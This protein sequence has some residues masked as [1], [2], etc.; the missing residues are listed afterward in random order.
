MK[1]VADELFKEFREHSVSEFFRKNAAMLG[2]TGKIRSLTTIV[3]E[4]VTN[5]VTRDTAVIIRVNGATKLARIGELIDGLMEKYREHVQVG[6]VESL[7]TFDEN[8]EVLCFDKMTLKM[9]YKRA[10]SLHRHKLGAGERLFLL[11]TVGGR[12][13]TVTKHHSLFTLSDGKVVPVRVEELRKGDFVIVPR[14]WEMEGWTKKINILEEVLKLPPE[15][16]KDV[17]LY[18]VKKLLYT[19]REL[20]RKIKAP[21]SRH[22]RHYTF[23]SYYMS[24]DRL[25]VNLLRH[26]EAEERKAFGGC[27]ISWRNCRHKLPVVMDVDDDLMVI[28]GLYSAE[29]CIRTNLEQ[30]YLSFGNNERELVE[31]I[32][33]SIERK[34][35]IRP[36]I[37]PAHETAINLVISSK[38]VAF[39]LK[40]VLNA[41]SSAR[42]KKLP[43]IVLNVPSRLREKYLLAYISG[44][45][46]PTALALKL[47]EN[48]GSL[49]DAN[50]KFFACNTIS[51]ELHTGMQY[52][53][54]SLGYSYSSR[55]IKGSE[56]IVKGRRAKFRDSYIIELWG[57]QINSPM[58][59]Y[60]VE[61]GGCRVRDAKICHAI[62]NCDQEAITFH[63]F[64]RL[65][66]DGGITVPDA[67][68]VFRNGDLSALKISEIIEREGAGEYVYDFSVEGDENFVGGFGPICLHNSIDAAEEAGVLPKVNVWIK[69]INEEPEH[70]KVAIEDN[71]SGIPDKY[72]PN[73]FGKML[74]GTKLHRHQ[75][76]RGQQGIGVSGSVM[77]GQIT[78]GKPA[79]VTT[80]TGNGEIVKAGVMIDVDKNEGKIL[81][82]EKLKGNWRG[83]RVEIEA[84]DVSY[85]RSRYGPF[86]YL[87]MTAIANPHVHITFVEP[88]GALTVFENATDEVPERPK[89]MPLHPWGIMS[90]D[91][92][93][94]AKRTKARIVTTFLSTELS[95]VSKRKAEEVCRLAGVPPNRKPLELTWEEAEHIV[96]AFKQVKLLA[97]PTSGLRPIGAADIEKG[98]R[99]ILNP[100]FAYAI[101]RPP[102][103]YRG[104]LPFVVE[105]GIA[106]GGNAGRLA[107]GKGENDEGEGEVGMDLIRFANR[108]PLIF[109]QGGCAI[110]A[111]A[112]NIEWR[113]YGV[114][115]ATAPLTLFVNVSSAYVPYT[116]AGK[117][118]IADEPEILN[119]TRTAIMEAAR[120]LRKFLF[121]K[122]KLK[123]RQERAGVFEEYLPVIARKAASL[124]GLREPDI[125]PLLKKVA[126][127]GDAGES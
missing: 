115:P 31:Y 49:S 14:R 79:T 24:R 38:F 36:S 95:R 96:S 58:N 89:P 19:D 43:E 15:L 70:L 113:R 28:L 3:H 51:R 12:E 37:N 61:S 121:R 13:V 16:T 80:S 74:A 75:Q 69:R 5:S 27:N 124:A 91:L 18:G 125:K 86:N 98:M 21:L 59:L 60:P 55:S 112:R 119:E 29:G 93:I 57:R 110:T 54:S 50:L 53:V 48:G 73:V 26:L 90:D 105:V 33:K 106:Y 47:M 11:R 25:P 76:A 6:D 35:G 64:D 102:K 78:S 82:M 101:T 32:S 71:A 100:E 107:E 87:R 1:T 30:T 68:V 10:K 56:R 4:G 41:G 45:G 117:Q 85:M 103:V 94:L 34:F 17:S 97:P 114:D 123:E 44:D 116:S 84:K 126:G 23:Y 9:K 108:A 104:G 2:Y 40:Y 7:R 52:L 46:Y 120:E 77:Y 39:L 72:I 66:M 42:D 8:L 65:L 22:D 67:A 83:T 118:S 20:L 99:Q 63:T 62:Q 127:V 88:D 111:A 92:L 109:D 81:S 122:I